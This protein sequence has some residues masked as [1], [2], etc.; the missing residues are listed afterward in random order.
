[1]RSPQGTLSPTL[2]RSL[3]APACQV[4]CSNCNLREICLP[5]GM[6]PEELDRVEDRL[7]T[8]RR[9]VARNETLFRAGDRSDAVF[10]VRTGFFKTFARSKLG[11]EQ[12][13]GFQMAGELIGLSGLDTG[14]HAVDAVALEDSQVCMIPLADLEALEREVPAL[15]ARF[16]RM[17]SHEI[18]IGHEAMLQLGSMHA[19]ERV[20]AFLLNL[21]Y[22]LAARG[23]SA[24][25]LLLR[26]SR[27][28][29]GSYLGL[30][31]ETV[32]RTLSGFQASGLLVVRQRLIEVTDAS[33]LQ[34]VLDGS[35]P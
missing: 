5:A 31:A 3:H 7:V 35:P 18:A 12:V 27:E 23:F 13:T 26:M 22:R 14:V 24:T 20:A 4:H 17:M 2:F 25:S 15:Q 29:I 1:M 16:H 34:R 10:A 6:T 33:G 32:S 30:T 9:K 11:E 19:E 21:M 8:A 28:E